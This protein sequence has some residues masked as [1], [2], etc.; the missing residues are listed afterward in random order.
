MTIRTDYGKEFEEIHD[1]QHSVKDMVMK[2]RKYCVTDFSLSS[3][4]I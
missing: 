1:C 2:I 4:F 3:L